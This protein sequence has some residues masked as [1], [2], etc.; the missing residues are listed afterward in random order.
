[1]FLST[2]AALRQLQRYNFT[3]LNFEGL[4]NVSTAALLDHFLCVQ[5]KQL[6]TLISP[7]SP[8]VV[9]AL[10]RHGAAGGQ[11]LEAVRVLAFFQNVDTLSAAYDISNALPNGL[12]SLDL[13]S[14]GKVFDE[15]HFASAC[16]SGPPVLPKRPGRPAPSPA[17]NNYSFSTLKDSVLQG[18]F[19]ALTKLSLPVWDPSGLLVPF[20]LCLPN[21]KSFGV[22]Y[23][24]SK[25]PWRYASPGP[26]VRREHLPEL[27][28][29]ISS[30]RK[31]ESVTLSCW[32]IGA[33]VKAESIEFLFA[34]LGA[35]G[36]S[37]QE[38]NLSWFSPWEV[39]HQH[40]KIQ[41]EFGKALSAWTSI[42][43]LKL[44]LLGLKHHCFVSALALFAPPSIETICIYG[45][46]QSRHLKDLQAALP[47]VYF[48]G[49]SLFRGFKH[50]EP[51]PADDPDNDYVRALVGRPAPPPL[52]KA[53]IPAEWSP[54]VPCTRCGLQMPEHDIE[55]RNLLLCFHCYFSSPCVIRVTCLFATGACG[56]VQT[57]LMGAPLLLLSTEVNYRNTW[58]DRAVRGWSAVPAVAVM[59][60]PDRTG[61]GIVRS[62]ISHARGL[63]IRR[64]AIAP[65]ASEVVERS[66]IRQMSVTSTK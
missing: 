46:V 19:K 62:T 43:K 60:S 25:R 3:E 47:R 45:G 56:R 59:L 2:H 41:A 38:F 65:T 11:S 31:L 64:R 48:S 15:E 13:L 39:T 61:K 34:A 22:S 63:T 53:R 27:C 37:L 8:S 30:N 26:F 52:E 7:I 54:V 21:L 14:T 9:N 29:T 49:S 36:S 5:P 58:R 18:P 35:I 55:V 44:A 51:L 20:L 12:K 50:E 4:E 57:R 42:K 23:S 17:N 6:K 16:L 24:S 32:H 10:K 40:D 33:F 66:R 1:M 28:Q